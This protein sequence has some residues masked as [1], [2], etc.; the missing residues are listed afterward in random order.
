[1]KILLASNYFHPEHPGGIETVA[2]NLVAGYRAAGHEVRWTAADCG[3]TAHRGHPDDV[4]LP[5]LNL[6]ERWLGVPYPL[7][8]PW[9]LRRLVAAA[10]WCDAVHLHDCLYVANVALFAVARRMRRPILLTQHIG[11]VPYSSRV[12]RSAMEV[13]YRTI[14]RRLLSRASRVTF[15]SPVVRDWFQSFVAF[16]SEPRVCPNGV[17]TSLF[18]PAAHAER[19]AL[20][21]EVGVRDGRPLVLFV[22]RFV[23]KKGI[24]LLRPVASRRPDWTWLLAGGGSG[25]GP[26]AWGLPNVRALS[27]A[28]HRELRDLYAAADLLVLPSV[29]EGLPM[30]ILEAL[31]CGTPVLTTAETAAGAGEGAALLTTADRTSEAIDAAAADLLRTVTPEHRAALAEQAA[32]RWD[33]RGITAEYLEVISEMLAT[34][35]RAAIL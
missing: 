5:A 24:H 27:W 1:V 16:G 12:L 31:A 26:S 23:E 34:H 4:G 15:V 11:S 3:V 20:R 28:T 19:A 10:A 21:R 25:A 9:S 30:V 8:A 6:T 32:R 22:G 29:G 35:R 17:D 13:A 18:R 7:P 33:W 2:H 14:G